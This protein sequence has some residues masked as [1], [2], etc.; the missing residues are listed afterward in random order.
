[1]NAET[2]TYYITNNWNKTQRNLKDE[3]LQD[4]SNM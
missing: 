3:I 1:M 4:E 2:D